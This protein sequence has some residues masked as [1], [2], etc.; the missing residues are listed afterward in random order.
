M[1]LERL[2]ALPRTTPGRQR[3]MPFQLVIRD[4]A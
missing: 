3:E 4:S 1:M 2:R